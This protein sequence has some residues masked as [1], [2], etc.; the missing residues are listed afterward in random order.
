LD[1]AS[2]ASKGYVHLSRWLRQTEGLWNENAR[3]NAAGMPSMTLLKQLDHLRK[4][5]IQ[6]PN[7]SLRVVYAA[8][9][10][11]PSAVVVED[12]SFFVEHAAYWVAVRSRAEGDY[13]CAIINSNAAQRRT[14][15]MQPKG[16]GGA[17]HFDNLIWE[18][19]IPEFDRKLELHREI[20]NAGEEASRIASAVQLLDGEYFTAQRR[21]IRNAL[22]A[23][24]ITTKID[25][26]VNR[27]LT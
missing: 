5:T 6:I 17:R 13:L 19:K 3:K 12:P 11:L 9:G 8:S 16:Q 4:L 21:A 1:A 27:L 2:A 23:S 26:L 24:G 22:A 14:T 20:A 10:I 15:E 25:E 18:L 7:R